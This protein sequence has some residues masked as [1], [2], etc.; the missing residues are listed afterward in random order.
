M[1]GSATDRQVTTD[2]AS[3]TAPPT[4]ALDK[5]SPRGVAAAVDA[6]APARV[7]GVTR[8]QVKEAT[9][10][11]RSSVELATD[12][13]Q[14][15]HAS[16]RFRGELTKPMHGNFAGTLACV[17]GAIATVGPAVL[18]FFAGRPIAEALM[19]AFLLGICGFMAG[20]NGGMLVGASMVARSL[21]PQAL[22]FLRKAHDSGS[23]KDKAVVSQLASVWLERLDA[24]KV[25]GFE[26]RDLLRELAAR[27]LEGTAEE[28]FEARRDAGNIVIALDRLYR[29]SAEVIDFG[30]EP[31]AIIAGLDR[32]ADAEKRSAGATF[33]SWLF[34]PDG[35]TRVTFE[36]FAQA[37]EIEKTLRPAAARER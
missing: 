21:N 9:P 7:E 1:L 36:D 29:A 3:F 37:N 27:P 12:M 10:I 4:V 17:T 34:K 14:Q 33:W 15:L 5:G 35:G 19:G 8:L 24:R 20:G 28:T 31:H 11:A 2:L 23:L 6:R 32:L 26:A 30:G 25:K 22:E 16:I 18:L 13:I